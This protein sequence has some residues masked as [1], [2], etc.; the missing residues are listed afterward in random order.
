MSSALWVK[1]SDEV[2]IPAE[3]S[4]EGQARLGQVFDPMNPDSPWSRALHR[5]GLAMPLPAPPVIRFVRGVPY[6]NGSLLA[7][8]SSQGTVEPHEGA[9]G[10]VLYRSRLGLFGFLRLMRAQWRLEVFFKSTETIVD[11]LE[12]SIALGIA[13]Q[14]LVQ[15]LPSGSE[16]ET[17][18]WLAAPSAAPAPL[19]PTLTKL[20]AIQKRRN[21]LSK[22]WAE[23]FPG[24]SGASGPRLPPHFWDEP[25]PVSLEDSVS[26]DVRLG[27]ELAGIPI[28]PGQVEALLL[29]VEDQGAP[30]P[31]GGPFVLL[32]PRARPETTELFGSGAAVLFAEGGALSHACS[33]AREQGIV[34]VSGLGRG[35][36]QAAQEWRRRGLKITARVDG[37]SGK[38]LCSE[39]TR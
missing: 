32:F 19:R 18:A 38:V 21:E 13:I 22:A 14:S 8:V 6:F 34:C 24:A 11:P 12:E 4:A 36:V 37:A 28:G 2:G 9:D 23:L 15:R 31:P 16:R 20:L 1:V 17:A 29:L 33:V 3:L 7:W 30:L 26:D 5:L 10:G 39:L 25:P 27:R 35:L